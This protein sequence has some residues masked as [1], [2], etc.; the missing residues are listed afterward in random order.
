M[1]LIWLNTVVEDFNEDFSRK[2]I[3][4]AMSSSLL[5]E[6]AKSMCDQIGKSLTSPFEDTNLAIKRVTFPMVVPKIVSKEFL[7]KFA[8]LLNALERVGIGS[9]GIR[10]CVQSVAQ[11]QIERVSH[12]GSTGRI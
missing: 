7:S 9:S 2:L 6:V 1:L 11:D 4:C 10:V 3:D 8:M 12:G 5:S